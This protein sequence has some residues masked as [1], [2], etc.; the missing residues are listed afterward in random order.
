MLSLCVLA[1]VRGEGLTVLHIL[2]SD[3]LSIG[4][5]CRPYNRQFTKDRLYAVTAHYIHS[6]S[7][8]Y[9]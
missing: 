3:V 7:Y 8:I 9:K 1:F 5:M 4:Y 2:D 6:Y